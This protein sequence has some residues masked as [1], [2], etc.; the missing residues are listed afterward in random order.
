[1]SLLREIIL[2]GPIDQT[3]RLVLSA[4]ATF[5]N[6]KGEVQVNALELSLYLNMKESGVQRRLQWL[7]ENFWLTALGDS[8]W[9]VHSPSHVRARARGKNQTP[10]DPQPLNTSHANLRDQGVVRDGQHDAP[11][12]SGQRASLGITNC[13]LC[14]GS[15]WMEVD[16][17]ANGH[18]AGNHTVDIC[19][20]RGGP[21]PRATSVIPEPK[22]RGPDPQQILRNLQGL[23]L[24]KKELRNEAEG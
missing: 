11:R 2:H 3:Q 23:D 21:E 24:V 6:D 17:E 7:T 14:D 20:C 1:M 18:P 5:A 9:Q 13:P 16:P 12:G 4:L 15:G 19:R 22:S 8:S 10:L